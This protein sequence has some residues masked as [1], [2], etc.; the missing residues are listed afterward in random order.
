MRPLPARIFAERALTHESGLRLFAGLGIF[1]AIC[2]ILYFGQPILI[3]IVLSVLLTLLL[4]PAV[5]ALQTI[6]IPKTIAV[7]S[8]TVVSFAILFML[9]ALVAAAVANLAADCLIMKATCGRRRRTSSSPLPGAIRF[10]EP[11]MFC[12]I[13]NPSSRRKGW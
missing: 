7:I 6:G 3:P 2:A 9:A 1:L 11:L 8:V 10:S 13:F 4:G 12:T 5:R